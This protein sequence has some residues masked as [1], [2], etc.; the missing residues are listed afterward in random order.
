MKRMLRLLAAFLLF[1]SI[2]SGCSSMAETDASVKADTKTSAVRQNTITLYS[3]IQEDVLKALK[4]TFETRYPEITMKY[5]FAS[6]PKIVTK[7]ITE[8]QS[9]PMGADLVWLGDSVSCMRLKSEGILERADPAEISFVD[10]SFRDTDGYFAGAALLE[11]GIGYN[12]DLA[13]SE[14]VP[15]TWSGLADSRWS[16]KAV[17]TDPG[18]SGPTMRLTELLMRD[19]GYG[20]SFFKKLHSNLLTLE[21][22]PYAVHTDIATGTFALGVCLRYM[23]RRLAGQGKPIAFQPVSPGERMMTVS[24]VGLISGRKDNGK[25]LFELLLS[26]EGE[27]FLQE[28]DLTPVRGR[29]PGTAALATPSQKE[30]MLER[31][32]LCLDLFDRAFA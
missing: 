10:A 31:E 14:E 15:K 21:C 16:G 26:K 4:K 3:S 20:T 29:L 32:N 9:G 30:D 24:P 2:C 19:S 25:L 17:M 8:K 23:V 5:Y 12:S 28:N 13:S 11:L 22:S 6:S 1:T 18:A 7:L 27:N